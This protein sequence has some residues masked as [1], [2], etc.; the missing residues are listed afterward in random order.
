VERSDEEIPFGKD[1]KRQRQQQIPLLLPLLRYG[2]R[3]RL[4]SGI[5]MDYSLL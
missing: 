1:N 4:S 3:R 2:I 5:A